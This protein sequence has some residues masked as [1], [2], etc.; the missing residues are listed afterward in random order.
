LSKSGLRPAA[1]E[2]LNPAAVHALGEGADGWRLL[3]GLEG[4][5]AD[6]QEMSRRLTEM[7]VGYNLGDWLRVDSDYFD[8]WDRVTDLVAGA[9]M[10]KLSCPLSAVTRL[11]SD[12]DAMDSRVSLRASPGLGL[13]FAAV[14]DDPGGY[15]I[16]ADDALKE[17]AGESCWLEPI[18]Q[19]LANHRDE[20]IAELCRGLKRAFDPKGIF[21]DVAI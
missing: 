5:T 7:S 13:V 16:R 10:L 9:P 3:V 17:Y 19:G 15:A 1:V 20:T 6:T 18:P 12:L 21:P 2:M 14:A 8:L 11:A 4:S